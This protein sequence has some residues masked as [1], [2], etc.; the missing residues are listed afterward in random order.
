MSTGKQSEEKIVDQPNLLVIDP[1]EKT[2]VFMHHMLTRAGYEVQVAPSGKEGLIIAW[3][4]LPDI[5]VT[6]MDLADI[7]AVELIRK[8]R[9]DQ[10]TQ[11]TIIIG[12]THLGDPR[13]SAAGMEA[14]LDHFLMKQA[15]AIDM[16]I[17]Y[18]GQHVEPRDHSGEL[19]PRSAGNQI[20]A[21]LG[22]KGGVGTSSI[23]VNVAHHIG[24]S[25]GTDQALVCDLV[26]P[27]GSLQWIT[28]L[29]DTLSLAELTQTPSSDLTQSFL[30]ERLR[31]PQG[32]SFRLL[33]G[34]RS[35]QAA[36]TVQ[37]DRIAPLLQTLKTRFSHIIVDLGRTISPLA[38]VVMAQADRLII[39]LQA[40]EECVSN[41]IAIRD[42]LGTSGIDPTQIWF[43][44]NR[45]LPTEGMTTQTVIGR[46]GGSV[47]AAIP[48]MAEQMALVNT[49]HAPIHLRFPEH[50]V[51]L[52]IQRLAS[53]ILK[54][55]LDKHPSSE[56]LA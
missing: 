53:Q 9:Q 33:A 22:V 5:I 50:R 1:D 42:Y 18:L 14:G 36:E 29:R 48:N 24:S 41:A 51:N 49:L 32:W 4:D 26:L 23:C 6:E 13:I 15:D 3:R 31:P 27:L 35:P 28:G 25:A 17:Q 56:P 7:E 55:E 12:L 47:A 46:L 34:E 45:P 8:L 11:R 37:A 21:F 40:D 39:L 44:S 54:G 20:I 30:D 19:P 52:A 16:L 38:R 2:S 10:R 43:V